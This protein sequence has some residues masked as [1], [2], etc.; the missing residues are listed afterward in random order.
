MFL[1][2]VRAVIFFLTL[3]YVTCNFSFNFCRIISGAVST[4][5][6]WPPCYVLFLRISMQV[7]L[8]QSR[9][10]F[11]LVSTC[12]EL[13]VGRENQA[14]SQIRNSVMVF[15]THFISLLFYFTAQKCSFYKISAPLLAPCAL[16]PWQM[17]ITQH[18]VEGR[19]M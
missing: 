15:F 6:S 11:V 3:P 14:R 19:K 17:F 16:A 1:S 5:C 10:L 18:Q 13:S 7:L 4:T 8:A 12:R 2:L 9:L